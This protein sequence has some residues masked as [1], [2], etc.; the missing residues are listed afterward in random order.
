[1]SYTIIL[2]TILLIGGILSATFA[3]IIAEKKGQNYT[4]FFWIGFFFPILG[5][6]IAAALPQKITTSSE[7]QSVSINDTKK[8]PFCAETIKQEAVLCR[9]CGK[10][11]S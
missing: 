3:G 11:L 9:W 2:L 6:V 4:A 7:N 5:L 10:S 1:M 8:C